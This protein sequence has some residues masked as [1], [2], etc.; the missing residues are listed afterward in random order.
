MT[1]TSAPATIA[2]ITAERLAE[3]ERNTKIYPS[4]SNFSS[5][6]ILYMVK[7]LLSIADIQA[8]TDT[9]YG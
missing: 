8:Y 4:R 2:P 5:L 7:S 6:S 1:A 3:S 9:A